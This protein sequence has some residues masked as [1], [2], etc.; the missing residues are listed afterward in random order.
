MIIPAKQDKVQRLYIAGPMTGYKDF[1]RPA[2]HRAAKA[3]REQNFD[4]ASPAELFEAGPHDQTWSFYMKGAIRMMLTCDVILML[5]N[6][7]NSKG[8]TLEWKIAQEL[9]MPVHYESAST[10][11]KLL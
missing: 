7:S 4:V 10:E 2:F 11:S 3:A 6:W 1:N 9:Q 5:D 8:A